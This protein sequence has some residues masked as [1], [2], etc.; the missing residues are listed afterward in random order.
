MASMVWC[1][2]QRLPQEKCPTLSAVC[3]SAEVAE[4]V[5]EL[6]RREKRDD[7]EP[8]GDWSISPWTV[9]EGHMQSVDSADRISHVL[10]PMRGALAFPAP[11]PEEPPADAR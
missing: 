6:S 5:V 7:G 11:P 1:V 10:D 4:E 2:F 3:A 9:L 8:E